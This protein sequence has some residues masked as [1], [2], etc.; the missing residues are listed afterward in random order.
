MDGSL[1]EDL[2]AGSESRAVQ[3]GTVQG[4]G[5]TERGYATGMD[6]MWSAPA[7]PDAVTVRQPTGDGRA[8][9][10][11]LTRACLGTNSRT[12]EASGSTGN[13]VHAGLEPMV[14]EVMERWKV[15]TLS[16]DAAEGLEALLVAQVALAE[17]RLVRAVSASPC[18]A[19]GTRRSEFLQPARGF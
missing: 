10:S 17:V 19:H 9:A 5:I 8:S 14:R 7:V 13:V 12:R 11:S 1:F 2:I 4:Y 15:D 6:M 18:Q 3:G 16:K